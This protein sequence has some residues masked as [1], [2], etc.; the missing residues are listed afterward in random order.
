MS[1]LYRIERRQVL[2]V[3]ADDAEEA[4][5]LADADL[6]VYEEYED[7]EPE[8]VDHVDTGLGYILFP[9]DEE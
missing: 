2:Y 6:T 4:K 8:E 3:R 7:G 5:E 9:D 1:K